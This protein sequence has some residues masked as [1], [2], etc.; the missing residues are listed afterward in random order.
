M[1]AAVL[2]SLYRELGHSGFRLESSAMKGAVDIGGW[3]TLLTAWALERFPA[4]ALGL[5]VQMLQA[6]CP[7]PPILMEELV[8]R[9][10]SVSHATRVQTFVRRGHPV[11]GKG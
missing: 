10:E 1:G 11:C 9:Q 3:T 5:E 6:L 8:P 4:I 2:S 7:T